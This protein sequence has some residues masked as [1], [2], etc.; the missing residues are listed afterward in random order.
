MGIKVKCQHCWKTFEVSETFINR[1]KQCDFC[2]RMT[3]VKPITEEKQVQT[4]KVDP[5]LQNM[6]KSSKM[7]NVFC[8]ILTLL[9]MLN[10]IIS[11]S[12]NKID[13]TLLQETP[14]WQAELTKEMTNLE[15]AINECKELEMKQA[16]QNKLVRDIIDAL[17]GSI[18]LITTRIYKSRTELQTN[19]KKLQELEKEVKVLTKLLGKK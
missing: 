2:Q 16:N 3:I 9:T 14:E 4:Q 13:E 12:G 18:G 8:V 19:Y 17:E 15:N 11:F 7:L 1:E 10:I 5:T 6:I